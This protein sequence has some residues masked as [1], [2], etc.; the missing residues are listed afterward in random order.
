MQDSLVRECPVYFPSIKR[1][2]ALVPSEFEDCWR[3]SAQNQGQHIS[4]L[5][6]RMREPPRTPIPLSRDAGIYI[7]GR[8]RVRF[9]DERHRYALSV[10]S[11]EGRGIYS[12][13]P[14]ISLGDGTWI[15]DYAAHRNTWG[16][17]PGQGY[18]DALLNCLRDAV[19]VGV[20]MP[21]GRS[22]YQ[23][24]GLAY[25]ERFNPLTQMFTLH[26]PVNAQTDAAEKYV[27]REFDRAEY[28]RLW[29]SEDLLGV[30]YEQ[31]RRENEVLVGK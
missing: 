15:L 17:A 12:D 30:N 2:L 31:F 26:G 8:S 27:V 25:V 21:D 4:A 6:H 14:A 5:P 22:G 10:R 16:E 28:Q 13:K 24:L 11:S 3:W 18:N 23:V 7:P 19:P 1:A 9:S 29:P 20:M